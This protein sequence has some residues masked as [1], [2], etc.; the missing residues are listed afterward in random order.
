VQVR[1][2]CIDENQPRLDL[3]YQG[4]AQHFVVSTEHRLHTKELVLSW[5]FLVAILE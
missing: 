5:V 4:E 1:I 3:E 2:L